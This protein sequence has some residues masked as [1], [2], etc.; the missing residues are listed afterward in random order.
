MKETMFSK[1]FTFSNFELLLFIQTSNSDNLDKSE[2]NSKNKN[3]ASVE[4]YIA[5]K[6]LVMRQEE[7]ALKNDQW[8]R[9]VNSIIFF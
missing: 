4:K 7:K 6:I 2:Q 9:I 8:N 3:V 1:T 5:L